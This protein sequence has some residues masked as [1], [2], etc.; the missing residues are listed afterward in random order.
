MCCNACNAVVAEE[1]CKA[2]REGKQAGW[3]S[4]LVGMA[5]RV[6]WPARSGGWTGE[7][8]GLSGLEG[9]LAGWDGWPCGQRGMDFS[10]KECS[11]VNL[12]I[13]TWDI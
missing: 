12:S 1:D 10:S 7:E 13:F 11:R 2:V 9:W 8:A 6:G 5:G 4:K 3:G